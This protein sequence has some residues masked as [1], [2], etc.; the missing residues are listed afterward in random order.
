MP[1]AQAAT[2]AAPS[3]TRP[4]AKPAARSKPRARRR[5]RSRGA[6]LWIAVSAVLLAG[7]VFVNLAVLQLNL[8]VDKATQERT[9]LRA[10]NAQL[11]SALSAALASPRIQAQA[12]RMDGLV[13][14][15]QSTYVNLGR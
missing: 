12:R 11:Q 4:R 10:T 14:A 5:A 9:Q 13:P 8:E 15:E 2:V 3:R 6:I 7:V 1:P